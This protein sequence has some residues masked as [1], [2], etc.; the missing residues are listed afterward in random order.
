MKKLQDILLSPVETVFAVADTLTP[1]SGPRPVLAYGA[2]LRRLYADDGSRAAT[3]AQVARETGISRQAV[4][5][6]HRAVIR[7]LRDSM[8]FVV[9]DSDE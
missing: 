9:D 4:Y 8:T 2:L 3:F 7:R 5:Q 6:L 1:R